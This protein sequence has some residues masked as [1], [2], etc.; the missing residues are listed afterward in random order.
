MTGDPHGTDG[1][2]RRIGMI[3]AEFT[4]AGTVRDGTGRTIG[5]NRRRRTAS[6]AAN[7]LDR[8]RARPLIDRRQR[9]IRPGTRGTGTLRRERRK[10]F[11]RRRWRINP[12]CRR[13]RRGIYS[14]GTC[15]GTRSALRA[16]VPVER[17]RALPDLST[18]NGELIGRAI[19]VRFATC[20]ADH[21]D[22]L[23]IRIGQNETHLLP[24]LARPIRD[25]GRPDQMLTSA[26]R[27][28]I[29]DA[30]RSGSVPMISGWAIAN[31]KRR[32]TG[33]R[34]STRRT[35]V[36]DR[37][38]VTVG[39]QYTLCTAGPKVHRILGDAISG[40]RGKSPDFSRSERRSGDH[41]PKQEH[42][43]PPHDAGLT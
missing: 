26:T 12:C 29:R 14:I 16:G 20:D 38:A 25:T 30:L 13:H 5:V 18:G 1:T 40:T 42:Q 11:H 7:R 31:D 35:V 23:P 8:R 19:G 27:R 15:R 9:R 28:R 24:G 34:I 39:N 36:I 22:H 17:R 21:A 37:T 41:R 10:L 43:K 6:T 3:G 4:G 2:E 32:R 33:R